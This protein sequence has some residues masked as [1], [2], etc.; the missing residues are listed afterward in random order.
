MKIARCPESTI[1]KTLSP[2]GS[3]LAGCLFSGTATFASSQP[4]LWETQPSLWELS[5]GVAI[6]R[7]IPVADPQPVGTW[8]GGS[9]PNLSTP[10]LKIS[11]WGPSD[12]LTLSL[13]KTDVWDRRTYQEPVLPL[14]TLVDLFTS[15]DAPTERYPNYYQSHHAYDAPCPK[16]V[17]QV[18]LMCEDFAEIERPSVVTETHNGSSTVKFQNNDKTGLITYLP[19]MKR[20]VIAVRGVFENLE[21]PV[22]LRLYRHRDTVVTGK[23]MNAYGSPVPKV[24][25]GYDYNRD[26]NNGPIDPPMSGSDGEIFWIRQ[27]F[28]GEK[29]FPRWF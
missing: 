14:Q 8:G 23:A 9:A 19:M 12:R 15:E 22:A 3:V 1:L 6:T 18:I 5:Q 13:N 27:T 26:A 29:T 4:P 7:A 11:L 10:E 20:N 21:N 2:I 24:R 28:P 17:G 25:V 16:P